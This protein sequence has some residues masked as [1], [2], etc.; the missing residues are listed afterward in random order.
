MLLPKLESYEDCWIFKWKHIHLMHILLV[1]TKLI[2]CT[3]QIVMSMTKLDFNRV[4]IQNFVS[5]LPE[6]VHEIRF[7]KA[8]K[9]KTILIEIS[10]LK[11]LVLNTSHMC[12]WN[13]DKLISN[14]P[15]SNRTFIQLSRYSQNESTHW[16]ELSWIQL[17]YFIRLLCVI[18]SKEHLTSFGPH[19]WMQ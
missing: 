13:I 14:L 7:G 15:G 19:L 12:L 11:T 2:S 18:T 16:N 5:L 1:N 6:D 9:M 4:D 10:M 17:L 3:I 8:W